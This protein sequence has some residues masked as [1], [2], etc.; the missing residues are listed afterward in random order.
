MPKKKKKE[1]YTIEVDSKGSD[2]LV[3][4]AT[5]SMKYYHDVILALYNN[6]EEHLPKLNI[7]D[8]KRWIENLDFLLNTTTFWIEEKIQK[9]KKIRKNNFSDMYHFV[10][11]MLMYLYVRVDTIRNDV[12]EVYEK[13]EEKDYDEKDPDLYAFKTLL[14]ELSDEIRKQLETWMWRVKSDNTAKV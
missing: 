8:S 2:S 6:V 5:E 13:L 4:T 11:S 1:T 14:Q 10:E 12:Q 3:E 7:E 9:E